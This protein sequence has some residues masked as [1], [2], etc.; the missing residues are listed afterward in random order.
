M[1]W[2]EAMFIGSVVDAVP[3]SFEKT[4]NVY[5]FSNCHSPFGSG[6]TVAMARQYCQKRFPHFLMGLPIG[7]SLSQGDMISSFFAKGGGVD[8][9]KF[10]SDNMASQ[11]PGK[12]DWGVV[13]FPMESF[14]KAINY[15]L[16][17]IREKGEE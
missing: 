8:F 15:L 17:L 7:D 9:N 1:T 14:H 10:I 5:S 6:V 4:F 11:I 2:Q 3:T 13:R 16:K 12:E